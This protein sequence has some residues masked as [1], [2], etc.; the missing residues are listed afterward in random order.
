MDGRQVGITIVVIGV[1]AVV[2]GSMIML[3]WLSWFGRLPGD[4]RIVSRST[5][6]YIP[7]T[8]ML[9]ISVVLTV[10]LNLVRRLPWL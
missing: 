10:V 4:I 3:G 6:V 7:L 2:V 9:V 5:R 8:S 1:V